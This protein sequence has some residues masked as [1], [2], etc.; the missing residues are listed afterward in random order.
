[1]NSSVVKKTAISFIYFY[2]RVLAKIQL[3]KYK[4]TVIGITGTAGKSTTVLAANSIISQKY[5]TLCS[6]QKGVGLNS[7]TGIPFTLLGILPDGYTWKHWIKYLLL[8]KWNV[9]TNWKKYDYVILEYGIDV[10]NEMDDLLK[11]KVPEIGAW[12]STGATHIGNFDA[13][14]INLDESIQIVAHEE[15]KLIKALNAG[16]TAIYRNDEI[17]MKNELAEWNKTTLTD[18]IILSD[19]KLTTSLHNGKLIF[20]FEYKGKN[21]KVKIDK[22]ALT[23]DHPYSLITSLLIANQIGIPMDEAVELL[24][25]NLELPKG[26]NSIINGINHSTIIDSSYNSSPEALKSAI[27]LLS[28]Y[29]NQPKILLLGDMRELGNSSKEA[30]EEVADYIAEK[31]SPNTLVVTVG[32]LMKDYLIPQLKHQGFSDVQ[33]FLRAGEAGNYLKEQ[34]KKLQYTNSV[35]LVKGSQNTIFLE[36]AV[37]ILMQNPEQADLLLT[38]RGDHWDKMRENY[39]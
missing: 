24:E 32:P 16:N 27:N 5:K 22:Y 28:T 7:R 11:I 12:I 23:L 9:L 4:T 1:M 3:L 15:A 2:L 34:I 33:S 10:P 8:A 19:I 26:R 36:I 37:E 6:Y 14:E 35:I 13:G 30:H 38:R 17:H 25:M 31:L 18:N 21:Y 20:I 39:R 29:E